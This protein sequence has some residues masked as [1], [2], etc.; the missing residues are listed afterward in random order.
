M[1]PPQVLPLEHPEVLSDELREV[2]A[3]YRAIS[4]FRYCNM[5]VMC[6]TKPVG[7]LAGIQAGHMTT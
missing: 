3:K 4:G 2:T 1:G 5:C 6:D 7:W